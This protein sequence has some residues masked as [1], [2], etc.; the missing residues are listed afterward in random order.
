MPLVQPNASHREK[1]IIHLYFNSMFFSLYSLT[2]GFRRHSAK[3][4]LHSAK[5]LPSV[6][7]GKE[8]TAKNWSAKPSLPSVFYRA[9]GKEK[10]PARRRFHW[11]S[12]CRVPTLQAL[13]KDFFNFFLKKFFA[14]CQPVRHSAKIFYFFKKNSLPSANPWGTRQR[15]FIFFEKFLCRVPTRQALGKDFLFF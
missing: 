9:L 14:E 11:R 2:T 3:V 5:P 12:L 4:K 15:A 1:W 6:T 8:H 7:L 10:R 13:G